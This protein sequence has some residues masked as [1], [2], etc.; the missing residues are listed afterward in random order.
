MTARTNDMFPAEHL[1]NFAVQVFLHFGVPEPDAEKASEVL[2]LSDLRGIDSHGVARL[3]TYFDMLSLGRINP[4]PNVKIIRERKSVCT[5]D[6]DN[7]LGLV[8]GPKTNEIAM[9]KA[10]QFGSGWV[11]VCNTNHYGIA[12]YYSLEA[13]K[14]EMLGW[15][16]TN[17][18]KLV[19]P[20][21]GAERMLGTNPISIAFPGKKNKPIVV[22][23]ATSAAAYGKIEIA[24]RKGKTIPR[25][26]IINSDG[27]MTEQPEDMINGGALLPLGSERELGG[28]KGYCLSAMVDILTSVLS[29]ANWGP[30][31]PPF[32]LRQEIPSRSVGKGIGHFF[33]AMQIEGFMDVDE[34]KQRI[35]E[36]IE[37][38][39]NTKPVKGQKA[40]LIP[41]DPEHEEEAIRR[42][43]G[44][45]LIQPVID[46][47]IDISKK[48]G[49]PFSL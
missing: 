20:L 40:V 41:G 44:I 22:D 3:H 15:S 49:I 8:V 34:F 4:K 5:V 37:V 45:P 21:W 36:W 42:K 46:D 47:L 35:D 17:S 33:G 39:R 11:S 14:R 26:W 18:T 7:G 10:E 38:F 12:S 23:L 9:D 28:H 6:G 1:R 19:A 32:A 24:K 30:F 2:I 43:E 29:G 13:L 31:T 25:G 48:T 16:M 27:D